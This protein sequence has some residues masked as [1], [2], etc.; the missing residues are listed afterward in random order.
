MGWSMSR[1]TVSSLGAVAVAV[2]AVT[3][4]VAFTAGSPADTVEA[5]AGHEGHSDHAG[6][7]DHPDQDRADQDHAHHL[8]YVGRAGDD[9]TVV[10]EALFA[11]PGQ[12]ALPFSTSQSNPACTNLSH[13]LSGWRINGTHAWYYK[14]A[15]AP[16]SVKSTALKAITDATQTVAK[17][18]N[19]CGITAKL[20]TA[21]RYAGST[22]RDVQVSSKGT[23]TGND[24]YNVIG[25]GKLPSGVLGYACVYFRSST[26]TVVGADIKLN[27][28]MR[29]FTSKPKNCSKT[30]DLR[31]VMAHE[32]GHVF[33]L[34]HVKQVPQVMSPKVPSCDTTK[35]LLGAGDLRAVTKL[36]GIG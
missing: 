15:N 23:C 5:S 21:H 20:S 18:R 26:K 30:Y 28:S 24:G 3:V 35:R 33:G 36:Y 25:W 19:R 16:S 32:Q 11:T 29:W 10:G 34:E 1:R 22:K 9:I 4:A 14:S 6:H 8:N 12:S 17:G 2:A 31:S 27:T 13:K 7:S